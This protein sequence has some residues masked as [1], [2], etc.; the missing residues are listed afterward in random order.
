MLSRKLFHTTTRWGCGTAAIDL[1][2]LAHYSSQLV[3]ME[4]L[5][6]RLEVF[7]PQQPPDKLQVPL[8]LHSM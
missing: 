5:K 3:L 2:T 1:H 7:N 8:G 6:Q 4:E